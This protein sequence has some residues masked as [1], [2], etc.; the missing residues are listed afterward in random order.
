MASRDVLAG[1]RLAASTLTVLR[2]PA[3][4]ID[5]S[6]ARNAMVVAPLAGLA[7]GAMAAAV[8][9]A[10][11]AGWHSSLVAAV[12]TVLTLWLSTG[13]LH[14]DGLA[15]TADAI[16]APPGRDRLA[17]MKQ[18][19]VGAFGISALAVVLV[20]Q[21]AAISRGLTAGLGT[22][23]VVT[24]VTTARLTLTIGCMRGVPAARADGLGAAVA[25]AVPRAVAAATA[26]ATTAAL[27]AVARVHDGNWHHACRV[28]WTVAAGI[29]AG[30]GCV[31][32]AT[33]RLGGITGDVLGAS[34]EVSTAVALLA[35]TIRG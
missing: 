25:G 33:R 16:G 2:L 31:A 30:A 20:I 6:A 4:R 24:A 18:P 27:V 3:G 19:T 17:I 10:A 35:A 28:G 29:V 12:L 26:L 7:L 8:G 11:R 9:Y 5:R 34:V 15:D 13:L 32:A 1:L 14:V 23:A 22:V 21:V